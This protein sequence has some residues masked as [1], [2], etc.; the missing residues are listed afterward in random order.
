LEF[1]SSSIFLSTTSIESMK[2]ISLAT[3]LCLAIVTMLALVP[4]VDANINGIRGKDL[5]KKAKVPNLFKSLGP[6]PTAP[7]ASTPEAPAAAAA[8]AVLPAP[9]ANLP[10]GL[11][12]T[13]DALARINETLA[14]KLEAK[15]DAKRAALLAPGDFLGPAPTA[16]EAS[17]PEE[18]VAAI[19]PAEAPEAPEEEAP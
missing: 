9:E 1:Y 13:N 6:A 15:R 16:P 11:Y 2:K 3:A 5:V 8:A 18:P 10:K 7:E 4:T 17:T 12:E 14:A 19:P